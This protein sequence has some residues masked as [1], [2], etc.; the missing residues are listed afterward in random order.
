MAFK[1]RPPNEDTTLTYVSTVTTKE[2]NTYTTEYADGCESD[3]YEGEEDVESPEHRP[4][5]K[6]FANKLSSAVKNFSL[7]SPEEIKVQFYRP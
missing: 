4:E 5:R 7:P 3:E 6:S 1:P 2:L